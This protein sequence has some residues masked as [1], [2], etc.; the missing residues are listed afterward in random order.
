MDGTRNVINA[1]Q[2]IFFNGTQ[3]VGICY[4]FFSKCHSYLL[5]LLEREN[6]A[7]QTRLVNF[8]K[9]VCGNNKLWKRMLQDFKANK[10]P[11]LLPLPKNLCEITSNLWWSWSW[12]ARVT[13]WTCRA[14]CSKFLLQVNDWICK[15]WGE[16]RATAMIS[17]VVCNMIIYLVVLDEFVDHAREI[18]IYLRFLHFLLTFFVD[19][20]Q[21]QCW[22]LIDSRSLY[23]LYAFAEQQAQ[24]MRAYW[25]WIQF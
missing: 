12:G 19:Q 18:Q 9:M 2:C 6:A 21:I 7:T 17:R 20:Y 23:V 8:F 16:V 10:L 5:F 1:L 25:Q 22:W 11:S 24:D 13:S 14:T 3:K 15:S 4:F